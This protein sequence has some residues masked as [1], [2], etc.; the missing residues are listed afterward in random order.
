MIKNEEVS[1]AIELNEKFL[2]E[3]LGVEPAELSRLKKIEL[4]IDTTCHN[5]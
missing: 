3:H 1:D 2:A 4:R 5:L